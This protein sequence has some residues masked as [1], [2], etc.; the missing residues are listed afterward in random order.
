ME[1]ITKHYEALH[2]MVIST[3]LLGNKIDASW[4]EDSKKII[5]FINSSYGMDQTLCSYSEHIILTKLSEIALVA[6]TDYNYFTND[7]LHENIVESA[8]YDL[9]SKIITYLQDKFSPKT[10][11]WLDYRHFNHYHPSI[12]FHYMKQ[13]SKT[14]NL[15]ACRQL[16]LLYALGIGTSIDYE[17]A[18][19]RLTQSAFWG[20]YPSLVLLSEVY[21]KMGKMEEANI[22][23]E[24]SNLAHL[25][26]HSGVTIIPKN[27]AFSEKAKLIYIQISSIFQDIVRLHDPEVIDYSFVEVMMLHSIDYKQKMKY[28]NHY[29][30]GLWKDASNSTTSPEA[31]FGFIKGV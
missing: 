15:I 25:Y 10:A 31:K 9:K 5:Q 13:A 27:A 2:F 3:T 8:F 1:L 18:V 26:L 22:Y 7:N 17:N 24:V 20:D 30:E 21:Q 14:G 4:I 12:H 23:K 6:D 16:G 29:K 28:I 19:L 11:W